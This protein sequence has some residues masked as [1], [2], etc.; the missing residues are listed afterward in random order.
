MKQT[1]IMN[2]SQNDYPEVT[3]DELTPR[4]VDIAKLVVEGKSNNEISSSLFISKHTVKTH[5]KNIN[6]KLNIHNATELILLAIQTGLL[7]T[8][9]ALSV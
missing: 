5:R 7:N 6:L 4:E 8:S 9:D 3:K 1:L 2:H